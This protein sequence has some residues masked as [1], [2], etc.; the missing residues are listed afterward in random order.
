MPKRYTVRPPLDEPHVQLYET[1]S[2]VEARKV[3]EM[4]RAKFSERNLVRRNS[5][6]WVD[7]L[8]G[9]GFCPPNEWLLGLEGESAAVL[10]RSIADDEK[11]TQRVLRWLDAHRIE[12]TG[13]ISASTLAAVCGVDGRTWRRWIGGDRAFPLVAARLLIEVAFAARN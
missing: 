10:Q 5:D 2:A 11:A 12:H 9:Y 4:R 3:A 1:N 6:G 7:E 8:D 13:R